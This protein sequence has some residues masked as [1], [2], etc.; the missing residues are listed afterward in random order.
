M[1]T[2]FKEVT[3][4]RYVNGNEMKENSSNVLDQYFTKPSVAL[5]CFQKACEVIKKYENLDDFIFLEPSAGDGVFYDLFPKNRRI[6]IDIEPK[7]DGFIQCD[8]LNYKL[9]THQKVICLGNPPF[10]HR[11]VMAL[12]FINHARNC[13]F[14]CFILPMFF[15]SQ[16]KGSIKYR[17]KGLNL[18]Y[19][20]RLEKNAFID[21]KNKEVDV[22]CVFQ[23]WSKK[24]QN[25][26]SEFSWYKN[27]HK[28]PFGEYIKVFTV[29]LAKN[30][31]CGKE[32]IFNQKASFYISSTF[33][34]STQ[35]VENFE[36]VKYK[37]GIAVV[38][39]SANKA[40]NTKLKKLFK[41]IDW[42]K[43][44]SLATNSCYHLGKSHIFQA[45]YDHL[46]SLKDN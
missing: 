26:K 40:L 36:E 18:L 6:G 9:P 23:I 22:H 1:Q 46:D 30:R 43:Y 35:I 42:T 8:F 25:K 38:F 5:K 14:V 20:E 29:S 41:E 31:E 3:P 2:L 13:D 16:G 12:E 10:G 33:Y 21:F 4:K 24:Y 27:R 44:A 11:G 32:W 45:L 28:E 37:S 19:S 17:V 15:E 7:R 34:K 39:T